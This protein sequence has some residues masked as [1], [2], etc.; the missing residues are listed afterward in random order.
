MKVDIYSDIV[1]PWCYIGKR[2]FEQAV[3]SFDSD[4]P[5]DVVFRP[6]QL[7]PTAPE[8]SLPVRQYLAMRFGGLGE[9]MTRQVG[10]IAEGEGIRIDWDSALV[11]NTR[12]AHVVTMHVEREHGAEA[13]KALIDKLF[14]A[15]FTEGL[16]V[17]DPEVLVHLASEVGAD[18]P[19]VRSLLQSEESLTEISNAIAAA[20]DLGVKAVPTFV[21][22]GRYRVEGAQ[23][24][25]AFRQVLNEVEKLTR[26]REGDTGR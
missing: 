7:D 9:Q 18:P 14:L 16:D 15:H 10:S 13:Q 23:S 11:A 1:C 25:E 24:A 3:A 5:L 19:R 4:T 17:A 2:R 6:F 21:F 12:R 20:R 8:M 22:D 26:E